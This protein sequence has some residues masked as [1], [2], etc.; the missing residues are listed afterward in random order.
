MLKNVL[1]L[2]CQILNIVNNTILKKI[3][4]MKRTVKRKVRIRTYKHKPRYFDP[5]V[6]YGV[7]T[8]QWGTWH[9]GM[10]FSG[11]AHKKGL[12]DRIY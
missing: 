2:Q 9:R 10:G 7:K 11:P 4:T 6:I 5:E 12:A 8:I 3:I 1:H